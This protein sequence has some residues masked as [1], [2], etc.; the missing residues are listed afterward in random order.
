METIEFSYRFDDK[1]D[2]KEVF[3]RKENEGITVNNCCEMF[4][5]FM[6][7]AGYMRESVE[8]FFREYLED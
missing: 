6:E 5:D 7:S 2:N 8:T 3:I 1:G 4:L